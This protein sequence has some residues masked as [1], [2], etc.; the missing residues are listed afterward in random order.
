MDTHEVPWLVLP[1]MEDVG[2]KILRVSE[3]TGYISLIVRHNGVAAPHTHIGDLS[4]VLYPHVPTEITQEN[5][6]F[7]ASISSISLL[8]L[9]EK[10]A[11]KA[12]P[13]PP[14]KYPP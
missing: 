2:L 6:D 10:T 9:T 12:I 7:K 14:L 1:G 3:E 8:P 5:K 13:N 4:F 11:I